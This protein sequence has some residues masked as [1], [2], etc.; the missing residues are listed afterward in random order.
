MPDANTVAIGAPSNDG[1]GTN[2]GHVRIY[3]WDGSSWTQ[4]GADIDGESSYDE[5]GH[6]VS[7]PNANTVAIGASGN[8]GNGNSSGHVR[9]YLWNGSRWVQK[10]ADIDGE[11]EDYSGTSVSMPDASTVAIGASQKL[12][13]KGGVRIFNVPAYVPRGGNVNSRGCIECDTLSVGA[14]FR[15]NG[16]TLLVVNR[17]MLDSLITAGYDLSKVCV[18]HI[19]DFSDLGLSSS[20]NV[21]ISAWDVSNANYMSSMFLGANNFNQNIENWDVSNVIDM[22]SMFLFANSFNMPLWNWEIENVANMDHMFHF[23]SSFNQD[24]ILGV[25]IR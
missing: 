21:D 7:M 15:N 18:S 4:K 14:Y 9:I 13:G 8:D 10:V 1:N 11:I 20:F 12:D 16:D 24:L 25:W 2:S 17:A 23:A 3:S 5:S 6:S 19:L 22:S